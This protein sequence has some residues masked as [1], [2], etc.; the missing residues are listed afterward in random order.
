M[1]F[2]SGLV[3]MSDLRCG[4]AEEHEVVYPFGNGTNAFGSEYVG[5]GIC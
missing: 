4:N 1:L 2:L 5:T 3:V